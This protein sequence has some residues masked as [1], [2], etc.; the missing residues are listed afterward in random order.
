MTFPSPGSRLAAFLR[1]I[2][3]RGLHGWAG[4]PAEN[5]APAFEAALAASYGIECDVRPVADG[6]PIIFHDETLERLIGGTERVCQVE[7]DRICALRLRNTD[8]K[9]MTFAGVLA[10][11]AGRVPILAEIKSAWRLP[12]RAFL[13]R[14]AVAAASYPGPLAFMSFDPVLL[15][16]LKDLVPGIPRGLVSGALDRDT[17]WI[18]RLGAARACRLTHLLEWREASPAFV[19]YEASALPTP[20]TR[21]VREGLGLPLFAWTVRSPDEWEAVR[22]WADALIFE[23]W[24]PELPETALPSPPPHGDVSKAAG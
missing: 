11:V 8:T 20:V 16:A 6:T 13:E 5:T 12:E 9:V 22:P 23:G 14:L 3:H 19:A 4:G 2:A 10:L 17:A 18:A 1:P 21:F 7:A 24:R 15:A